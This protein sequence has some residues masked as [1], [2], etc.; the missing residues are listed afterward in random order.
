MNAHHLRAFLWLRW[1]LRLNQMRRGGIANA[2]ILG[3]LAALGIL[4]SIALFGV[5][6]FV[7]AYVLR[8]S[9]PA[10]VMYVWD[11]LVAAFLFLWLI[12]LMAD[13]QRAEAL[14]LGKLLHLPVSLTGAFLINYLSSLVSFNLILF[15]PA[16]LGLILGLTVSRGSALLL[17]L[18]VVAALILAV[19]ALTYQL[20]GW[21]AALMSNPR[22]RR[23]VIVVV[24]LVFVVVVQ[25]PNLLNSV[26]Q[27]WRRRAPDEE[28]ARLTQEMAK[29]DQ[30]HLAGRISQRD[31]DRQK[32]QL[33]F[34]QQA[35][36]QE[37]SRQKAE[38]VEQFVH[39]ANIAF[40]AGWV[41][42]SAQAVAEG[43][44]WVPLAGTLGLG[45]IGAT[46]LSRAY[47]TTLRLYTGQTTAAPRKAR[48]PAAAAPTDGKRRLLE[49]SLPG[50]SEHVS[51]IALA[52]FRSLTR[53][54]EAKMVLLTPAIMG[55]LFGSMYL[56][57][58]GELPGLARPLP[59]FGGMAMV[60]LG[61]V[62]IMGNQFGY[63]RSGFRVFVLC[64]A[65]RRDVLLGKNLAFAPLALALGLLLA[66]VVQVLQPMRFDYL[67]GALVGTMSM[68]LIFCLLANWL[69]IL[70]PMPV[71]A[72]ALKPSYPKGVP[73]LLH[74]ALVFLFPFAMLPVLAPL[75]AQALAEGLG[76]PKGIP[77]FVVLS[78]VEFGL[79][80][81][82]YRLVLPTQGR[83]LFRREQKIL[84]V[85]AARAE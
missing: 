32:G 70:A 1:R 78:L 30:D 47:R 4:A 18:P 10:V 23:T 8:Q 34:Q 83:L 20:Q 52:S 2:I 50:A 26:V 73:A 15:A 17:L 55:I 74:F 3:L 77:I 44:W 56:T 6:F 54:P 66:A 16:M 13:L 40:P 76:A 68:Y 82:L 38:Q 41:P 11:G 27:P 24:T 39:V 19:T 85:V 64:P 67:L 58:T 63:D 62:Q 72:G 49:R 59:V 28:T 60:L 61:M 81:L 79:V 14:S 48:A 29:L 84:Q 80:V 42:L 45:L 36:L 7:G 25:L 35:V 33:R 57:R 65:R 75:G 51:A 46:S 43:R 53:A 71:A 12:G 37:K 9:S 21:L 69:S 22:R 5:F 31:Y